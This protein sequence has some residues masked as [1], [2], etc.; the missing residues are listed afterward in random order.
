MMERNPWRTGESRETQR[1]YSAKQRQW[2]R[3]AL[4]AVVATIAVI[5]ACTDQEPLGPRV[6]T[7]D[8]SKSITGGSCLLQPRPHGFLGPMFSF[9]DPD[10]VTICG[11]KFTMNALDSIPPER[12]VWWYEIQ[13]DTSWLTSGIWQGANGQAPVVITTDKPIRNL[14]VVWQFAP[15]PGSQ[16]MLYGANDSLLARRDVGSN[17]EPSPWTQ[18]SW[19]DTVYWTQETHTFTET[20]V[21]KIR[22][23]KGPSGTNRM[24]VHVWFDPDTIFC[25]PYGDPL[26][27]SAVVRRELENLL[28]ASN[29]FNSDFAARR[30]HG[31]F[32]Y[33]NPDGTYRI[34]PVQT[35]MRTCGSD[36]DIPFSQISDPTLVA[37][38]HSHP[39]SDG[40]VA[41]CQDGPTQYAP[42]VQG[43]G[44]PTDYNSMML[45]NL[46]RLSLGLPR[47]R[48]IVIDKDNIWLMDPTADQYNAARTA[49]HKPRVDVGCHRSF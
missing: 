38:F 46:I 31:S 11:V 47:I 17:P 41:P 15:E 32:G 34:E 40:D 42:H 37:F 1:R 23:Q 43:G 4:F 27:D 3:V 13:N 14:K 8:P 9:L 26:I 33:R 44:S 39:F 45:Q 12:Y 19:P 18:S 49:V 21:R 10:T 22:V 30:E 36:V 2:Q 24:F 25:P 7:I 5:A 35:Q 29:A 20:A 28:I 48:W 6:P 16:M